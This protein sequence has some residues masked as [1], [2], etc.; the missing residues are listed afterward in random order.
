[1]KIPFLCRKQLLLFGLG[2]RHPQADCLCAVMSRSEY[3]HLPLAMMVNMTKSQLT[4]P[5]ALIQ[6]SQKVGTF[7]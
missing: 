6:A 5:L 1:M 3:C 7:P 4:L 2:L